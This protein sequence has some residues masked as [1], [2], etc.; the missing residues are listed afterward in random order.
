M[1]E[2]VTS[3]YSLDYVA[4]EAEPSSSVL[5]QESSESD[6]EIAK[7]TNQRAIVK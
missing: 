3:L 4:K 5:I 2:F 1:K 6:S 7:A